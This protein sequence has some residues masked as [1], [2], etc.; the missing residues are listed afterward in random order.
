[1]LFL[2]TEYTMRFL[3]V[4]HMPLL[5]AKNL[6]ATF[7][8]IALSSCGIQGE[9]A[10]NASE[11]EN[12]NQTVAPRNNA[13]AGDKKVGECPTLSTSSFSLDAARGEVVYNQNCARCH[14]GN[15]NAPELKTVTYSN[16]QFFRGVVIN[17]TSPMPAFRNI[18]EDDIQSMFIYLN[19]TS[20]I[21][22]PQPAPGQ[23]QQQGNEMPAERTKGPFED[24]FPG[25]GEAGN[26]GDNFLPPQAGDNVEDVIPP[27]GNGEQASDVPV[28]SEDISSNNQA[29][30]SINCF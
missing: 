26:T 4:L 25:E 9:D 28:K 19:P 22:P 23:G 24:A 20:S 17:G 18:V 10:L 13:D 27:V 14:D 1:M 16:Y 21:T 2:S 3:E 12:E 7:A 29:S 5:N 8:T 30:E 15:S 6:F 11:K